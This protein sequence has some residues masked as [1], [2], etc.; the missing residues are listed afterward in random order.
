M[1][2]Y[3]KPA[4]KATE[5]KGKVKEGVDAS[6]I[7]K[8]LENEKNRFIR[9]RK[10]GKQPLDKGWQ[11]GNNFTHDDEELRTHL[12]QGGNYG[13]CTGHDGLLVI[14]FDNAEF[15]DQVFNEFPRTFTV[16]TGSG[17]KHLYFK[18]DETTSSKI[19]DT[20]G[21][22]LADLQGEGKQVIGPGS[23][24]PNG[25]QYQ[26][27]VDAPIATMKRERLNAILNTGEE[28]GGRIKGKLRKCPFHKEKHASLAIYEDGRFYCFGCHASG[29]VE[30]LDKPEQAKSKPNKK[31]G[32]EYFIQTEK[33]A[34]TPSS[35]PSTQLHPVTPSYTQD[36][37]I[38][39]LD[40]GR[41]KVSQLK[42]GIHQ[43]TFYYGTVISGFGES[44]SLMP[45][46]ALVT[47]QR[48]IHADFKDEKQIK[49]HFG[50]H[51]RSDFEY[52][53]LDSHASEKA[54]KDFLKGEGTPTLP[55]LFERIKSLNQQFMFYP[56][57]QAHDYVALDII[58]TYFLPC[59]EAK[60]RTFLEAEKGSGKTRQCTIYKLLSF[61][62]IMSADISKS[63]FFRIM[64]GTCGTLVIDD[65]DSI[66]DEQKADI[67][68]HYKTGY[69]NTSKSV[70]TGEGR[71][72]K[73]ETFRNYGHV[74]MNN[75]TGLDD[76]SADRSVFLPLLK[77]DDRGLTSKNIN[78]H[79]V[80]WGEIRDG[81]FKAGLSYWQDVRDSYQSLKSE[82]LSGRSFEVS[83]AVLSLAKLISSSVFS[84]LEK[85]LS[86][87]FKDNSFFDPESDW[88]YLALK[89]FHEL[90]EGKGSDMRIKHV[91]ENVAKEEGFDGNDWN[92]HVRG[93]STFLGRNVFRNLPGVFKIVKVQGQ[94]VVR[95]V[96]RARFEA[97]LKT[98]GWNWV[99]LGGTGCNPQTGMV[100]EDV[101]DAPSSG[102]H[103]TKVDKT[104]SEGSEVSKTPSNKELLKKAFTCIKEHPDSLMP[105]D[106]LKE[107]LQRSYVSLGDEVFDVFLSW[108]T[109][110]GDLFAPRPGYV[111]VLE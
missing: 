77:T 4:Q 47:S 105:E 34:V 38:T 58:S 18:T 68:Q 32:Q 109:Q 6:P 70:R 2:P 89:Q 28:G 97:Y 64:E 96:S 19:T 88:T 83:R 7:P 90:D 54:F 72:R 37:V 21:E 67:L 108:A 98:K 52:E 35:T 43:N 100:Y 86:Q 63:S 111:G 14:D 36:F 71:V 110:N 101:E 55:D 93:I 104:L 40:R 84:R 87:R 1:T 91:A 12:Q 80:V 23:T 45:I 95:L 29:S 20:K 41:P 59:F 49:K 16:L 44:G 74:V 8:Q 56:E 13:V 82:L 99:E 75:T 61:N 39:L 66:G 25:K 17:G 15:Q 102:G 107:E 92:K 65:F 26:V 27:L 11:K 46:N 50:L 31:G 73:Q 78:E 33:K 57:D 85:W 9:V 48:H 24:H 42:C 60:G 79:D 76:I 51:Y 103:E 81:L 22:T 94:N 5:S 106:D 53:A 69:K 3:K 30:V 62:S 10:A